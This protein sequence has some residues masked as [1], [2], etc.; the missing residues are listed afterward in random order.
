M[1]LGRPPESIV[2]DALRAPRATDIRVL[3][4]LFQLPALARNRKIERFVASL[5]G[6]TIIQ[7][8]SNP[9][10]RG[11]ITFREHLSTLL[12]SC[13]PGTVGLDEHTRRHHLLACLGAVHHIARASVIPNGIP[14]SQYLLK[15]VRIKLANIPL[16]RALWAEQD[17]AIRVTA[18]SICSLLAR[19]L[20]REGALEQ[21]ELAWLQD[22]M[23]QSSNTISNR[24]N[25]LPALDDMNVDSFVYGILSDQT[26]NL[27][28]V[29]ATFFVKTLAILMNLGTQTAIDRDTF[30]DKLISLIRRIEEGGRRD[31]DNI[32]DKLLD[33]FQDVSPSAGPAGLQP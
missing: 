31:R 15:D 5:S 2:E 26:D 33:I 6:A 22:V 10:K 1:F 14:L 21:L 16:M 12:R 7:L 9:P 24:I 4:W 3:N 18:R 32:V 29:Q 11:K 13:A 28:I 8:F 20:L 25:D 17:P 23:G 27:P 19:H 30:A